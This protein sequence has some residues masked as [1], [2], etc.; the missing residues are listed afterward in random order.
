MADRP[1]DR[2]REQESPKPA[3][4]EKGSDESSNPTA[5]EQLDVEAAIADE[6]SDDRFQASDN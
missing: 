4:P 2:D 6:L 5:A 1:E 3:E